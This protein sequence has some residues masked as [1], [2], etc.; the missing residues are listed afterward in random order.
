MCSLI[1]IF[2]LIGSISLI[3]FI[4][5]S[6]KAKGGNLDDLNKSKDVTYVQPFEN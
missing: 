2:A 5:F 4:H 3:I 6:N 1:E